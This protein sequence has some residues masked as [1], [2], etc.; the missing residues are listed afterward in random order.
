MRLAYVAQHAFRHLEEHMTK[1]PV[2]YIMWRF[3]G[4]DDKE[5]VDFKKGVDL[6]QAEEEA[7]AQAWFYDAKQNNRLRKCETK[8]EEKQAVKPESILKRRENK[9]EKT[10]E[11]EVKWQFKPIEAA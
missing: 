2:Q 8:E 5:S 1:T 3:A 7:Q 9:K 10:K 6:S 4:N 11:Y